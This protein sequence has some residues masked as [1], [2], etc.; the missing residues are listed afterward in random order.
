MRI[1][2]EALMKEA[3]RWLLLNDEFNGFEDRQ[4]F[5]AEWKELD[6]VELDGSSTWF[7]RKNKR[8]CGHQRRWS[9]GNGKR[10]ISSRLSQCTSRHFQAVQ[11][12]ENTPPEERT[13]AGLVLPG[14]LVA[15]QERLCSFWV[16]LLEFDNSR[17]GHSCLSMLRHGGE[18]CCSCSSSRCT[19][20]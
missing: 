14:G 5:E 7:T 6:E 20:S 19:S 2:T 12:A 13:G 4:A 8:L 10:C 1:A 3:W 18:S 9:S 16:L 15:R 17:V 11:G